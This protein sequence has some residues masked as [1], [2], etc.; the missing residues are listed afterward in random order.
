MEWSTDA[1]EKLT[2]SDIESLL[3]NAKVRGRQEVIDI[4][5]QVLSVRKQ[6]EK[7]KRSRTSGSNP[8]KELEHQLD[9]RLVE[10]QKELEQIYDLTPEK[11][12]A[13]SVGVKKFKAH[14]QLS[15]TGRSKT[16]AHQT[17]EGRVLLDRYI[18]YRVKDSTCALMCVHIVENDRGLEFHVM[19]PSA[20]LKDDY[21]DFRALRPYLKDNEDLGS[22]EGGQ[23]FH[24]FEL[25]VDRYK[26]LISQVAPLIQR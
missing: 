10:V 19:G 13:L 22:Y 21:K 20:L 3:A 7:P 6:I 14:N 4:C 9:E 17:K 2:T 5:S 18:S 11:A 26:W 16:G 8:R 1:V 15:S 24:D 23:I 12:K 25:A